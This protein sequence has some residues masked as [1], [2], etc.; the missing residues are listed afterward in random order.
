[1]FKLVLSFFIICIVNVSYSQKV[2]KVMMDDMSVNFYD[3]CLEAELY[4][5][6]HDKEDKG[7]GWK[8]YQ[9][10]K[11]ANEYKYYPSGNRQGIDPFFTE[12]AYQSFINRNGSQTKSSF[13]SGWNELGPFIIDSLTGHYSAGL[14][15]I[16][17]HYV[18]PNNANL[19]Y[20]GSRSGGFWKSTNGGLNWQGGSTDF[21]VASG[22]NTIA[23]SPTNPDSVL[24]NIRNAR[25][26]NSHGAY[27][28]VDG[29]VT[30]NQS[31]FNP[32]NVGF[33][34]L[35]SNFKIYEMRDHPRVADLIFIGTSEG[36]YRSDDNLATWTLLLNSSDIEEIQFHPT[37][38][39]IIYLYDSYY[40]GNNKNFV[41]RSV[42]QGLS[43]SQSSEIVANAD[44]RSVHLSVSTDCSSCLYFAS[45]NGVWKSIDN[46]MN[47]TFLNNPPQ[48]CGGFAVNDI[49]T[50]KM[51]YGYVDIEAS[52][53][54]GASFNQVTYWSLGNTNGSGSG[55]QVSFNTSTNYVHADLHPAKCVNGVFYVGTDGLFAK[56]ND[57]GI[58]WQ[59]I[60]QG[61]AVRENYKLGASQSNHFRTISGSQDNGTSIKLQNKWVEFYGA[62]GMEALIHPLNDDWMISSVQ[63]GGRRRTK[64]AGQTQGGVSP[65]AQSGS[66]NSGWEA[67]IAYDPNNQMSIYNFSKLIYKS[68]DFGTSWDSIGAPV[69]FA[70]TI[71]KAAIAENNS[72]II[73]VS[74]NGTIEKSIDGGVTFSSI[75][76]NLPNYSIQDIAFDPNDDNVFI[77]AFGTYQN[78]GQKIYMTT[79]S[80]ITWDNI[81]YN[82]GD[83]PIRSVVIDHTDSSNIY[84]GAEIGVFTKTMNSNTWVLYNPSLPNT[85]VEELE[86]VYG[87]NTL[88]AATWGRGVWEY[89]LVDRN[90]FPSILFTEITDQPTDLAPIENIDQFVTSVVSYDNTLSSVYTEWSIDNPTFGN[91]I[92]MTNT[93]DSTWVTNSPIPNQ[94]FGTK[95]YFKV[96]AVGANNDTTETYKFMYTVKEHT[97]CISTGT[98]GYQGNVT[99]VNFNTINNATGK[100]QP[101]TDYTATDSTVVTQGDA[102]DLTVNLNTDNGNYTYFSKVWIDWNQDIDFNDPGEEYEIGTTTNNINGPTTLSP[103]S[104]VIP[105]TAMLGETTMRVSTRYNGYA[106]QCDEGYDGEV[107]DYGIH[108]VPVFNLGVD[109]L[110]NVI[111]QGNYIY[112]NY[113]GDSAD[114]LVWN[115]TNGADTF[116]SQNSTDSLFID[117]SG[118]Y[119]LELIAYSNGYSFVL[120]T[121]NMFTS[122]LIDSINLSEFTCDI[123]EVG[124]VVQHLSN[125]NGCDS[126][127]TTITELAELNAVISD[128]NYV[129]SANLSGLN[130]QWLNC[131]NGFS[132]IVGETYQDYTVTEDGDYAVIVTDADC[133]DTTDCYTIS[134]LAV[135]SIDDFSVNVFPNPTNGEINIA[136]NNGYSIVKVEVYDLLGQLVVQNNYEHTK[137]IKLNIDQASGIYIVSITTSFGD[138]V[139]V[140]VSKF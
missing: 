52:N 55:N 62:D 65:P 1:M 116:T 67:P 13:N 94:P 95:V 26:G 125:I 91:V 71:S 47:F 76:N 81:T 87:S 88:K 101:Y 19:M 128:N 56:S 106:S 78:N 129:L 117:Q 74:N 79:N 133:I 37:N 60:G 115:Y 11:N 69:T 99:W 121:S 66:G 140:K 28:S 12:N 41:M 80:G 137:L 73:L 25:D 84:I 59:V 51:I 14:G 111:C 6:K 34:G 135:S 18:D 29:G 33:G 85:T 23:V 105:Q 20:I 97:Y 68:D 103:F 112:F 139:D 58:T 5:N 70:A 118:V 130:Y 104:I 77:V 82:L 134:D 138:K 127:V 86:I 89:T 61:I 54:G 16:E 31:N 4:F 107:E 10:W 22:V 114:S 122:N 72:D 40:Y 44:S 17:D 90:D 131:D 7:S 100:T 49:D 93:I 42:D 50:T 120:N 123:L 63:Y 113:T 38:N 119:D 108:V 126:M 75:V 30:W 132:T 46:G 48:A 53:D 9:R 96:F 27:R 43:Y 45:D 15:R 102:Y 136:F 35:G 110:E 36:I 57:N 8:G 124:T 2:Y 98:M 21:T 92:P 32:T 24:I 83:M 109:L 3:V 64:D 39:N